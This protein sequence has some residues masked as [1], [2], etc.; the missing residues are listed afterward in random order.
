MPMIDFILSIFIEELKIK[1]LLLIIG[2]LAAL[3]IK[4]QPKEIF[5][6]NGS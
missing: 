5:L 2:I 3:F 4:D 6:M 1:F